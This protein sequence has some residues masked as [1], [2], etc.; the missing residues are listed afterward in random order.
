VTGLTKDGQAVASSSYNLYGARKTST[1]TTGNPFAYN[2]EARDDTG[3]DYLR[4]RYYDSQGGTFLT[5]DS[6]PGEDTDPLSQNRYSYVQ[7]NPVNYTDPSGH[8]MV[9][10]GGEG[11]P[12]R[13]RSIN[14]RLQRFYQ[15][16]IV[17]QDS[18]GRAVSLREY[19]DR[20][21]QTDR[22]FRAPA[23]YYQAFGP[24]VATYQSSYAYAQQQAERARAQAEQRR[25]QQI[26][27][28]Y[29]LATGQNSSPTI[30]EGLNLYRNWNTS[31]Q[32]TLKHVCTTAE[33]VKS[34]V[35]DFVKNVDWK[36]VAVTAAAIGVGIAL[37]VATGGLGAPVAMAIGGA[38]SGAII[39]GY[40]AYSSG[41]RGWELVGSIA[42]GAG[43]GAIS[44]LIGG[45]FVGAGASLATNVTQSISNQAVRQV[46]KIGVES[47]VETAIDTGIDLATG[48]K[49]T[50][51]TV[52][53][54]FA[55]NTFTNGAGSVS[56]KKAPKAD[57]VT[58][59]P[60]GGRLPMTVDN[61]Q[62]FAEK[63]GASVSKARYGKSKLSAAEYKK[64]RDNTPTPDL[65]MRVNEGISLPMNDF[66]IPGNVITKKLEADHIVP[67]KKIVTME[68]FDK[69]S[70]E[71]Q[72]SVLNFEENFI[73]LSKSANTSKG[74]KSYSDWTMYK[75]TN[76]PINPIFREEMIRKE[77]ILEGKLQSMIDNFIYDK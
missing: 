39:S 49:I 16:S 7:N 56:P 50:G 69:L 35:V 63:S 33:R 74:A 45:Q 9:W 17:E 60:T 71:Q 41:Q 23:S 28:E 54:N 19:T 59:K 67:M 77:A 22:N 12:S 3:L 55:F 2:G 53:M 8:R 76:T 24:N 4:A 18:L 11:E 47:A 51:Q 38:A 6:Y 65:R 57:V 52:A 61:L 20:R 73:G 66:A 68:G 1:D 43:T 48:N 46:A 15:R 29:G 5:E 31:L 37:T 26:R 44:G 70:S 10:M 25:R 21:I 42:K 62:M 64:L 13:P 27:Y 40:D 34:Q 30:R 32:N 75:K 36:K 14:T 72:L 58:T